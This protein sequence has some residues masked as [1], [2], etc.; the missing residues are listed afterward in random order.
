MMFC[1]LQPGSRLPQDEEIVLHLV[2]VWSRPS[3]QDGVQN[4]AQEARARRFWARRSEPLSPSTVL[5]KGKQDG[6]RN[7]N[8]MPGIPVVSL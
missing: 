7:G 3:R 6:R 5:L 4:G 8:Q 2:P 1:Q